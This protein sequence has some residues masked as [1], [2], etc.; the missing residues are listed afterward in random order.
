M[1]GCPGPGATGASPPLPMVTLS[2][3]LQPKMPQRL[4]GPLDGNGHRGPW[5]V[6]VGSLCW[7]DTLRRLMREWKQGCE[8]WLLNVPTHRVPSLTSTLRISCFFLGPFSNFPSS[9][10]LFSPLCD[11]CSQIDLIVAPLVCSHVYKLDPPWSQVLIATSTLV[12]VSGLFSVL[13][14]ILSLPHWKIS[15]LPRA[16]WSKQTKKPRKLSCSSTARFC[17]KW[18]CFF[19]A[20]QWLRDKFCT[21]HFGGLCVSGSLF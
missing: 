9:D 17:G 11:V 10:F 5:F 20:L 21:G 18:I 19:T 8:E 12:M 4:Q 15:L 14:N 3:S 16:Q 2:C 6:P 7:R 13:E 1:K